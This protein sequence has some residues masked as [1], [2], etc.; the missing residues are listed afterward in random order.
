MKY[1]FSDIL[2][3]KIFDETR[4]MFIT[5]PY[6]LFNNMVADELK[7]RCKSDDTIILDKE[8]L[9]MFGIDEGDT[10]DISN[11]VSFD[12]F[13]DVNAVANLN[14]KWFC[15]VDLK[16][17]SKKQKDR[18]N[19]YIKS[20]SDNGILVITS[21]DYIDYAFYLKSKLLENS[22]YSH[23]IQL[24][25]PNRRILEQIVIA[26]F[27]NKGLEIQSQSAKFFIMRMS[28]SYD[29]YEEVIERIALNI[30]AG[31]LEYKDIQ[32]QMKGIENYVID[33][34]IE[35]LLE[36]L[37]NDKITSKKIYKILVALIDEFGAK[38]LVYKILNIARECLEFRQFI[39]DGY[40]PVNIHYS[41]KEVQKDIG[42]KS[43]I[44]KLS[45]YQFRKKAKLASKTSLLDW[46]YI[47]LILS[48]V[49]NITTDNSGKYCEKALYTLASRTILH[50]SRL[51]NDI[52]VENIITKGIKE[53]DEIRYED[54]GGIKNE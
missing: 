11:S 28:D 26:L 18:L 53:L 16:S 23:L 43:K 12:T 33:D 32:E 50:E 35:I 9:S 4:V 10:S 54:N 21:T 48:N 29:N 17:L 20:P 13:M 30:P 31:K 49:H 25:W 52:G 45:E 7:F 36:P 24:S 51:N 37:A 27:N 6:N 2:E 3:S 19:D 47:I 42:D 8:T 22:K 39:N 5:G 40:I 38:N 34:F 46:Q 14:G 44:S 41:I 15:R 1:T